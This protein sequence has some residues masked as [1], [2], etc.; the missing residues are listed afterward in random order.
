MPT[1]AQLYARPAPV[2]ALAPTGMHILPVGGKRA[3]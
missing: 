1:Q 3:S 2:T